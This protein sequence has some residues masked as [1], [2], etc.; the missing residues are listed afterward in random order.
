MTAAGK[1]GAGEQQVVTYK[2]LLE[3][4][5]HNL[6]CVYGGAQC[7]R[8]FRLMA[9]TARNPLRCIAHCDIDSAYA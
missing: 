7:A 8:L 1:Q 9:A 2:H 5:D 3:R 4:Q 6:R